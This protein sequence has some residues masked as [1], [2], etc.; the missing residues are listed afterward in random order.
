[1]TYRDLAAR[2]RDGDIE[3][4]R[5]AVRRLIVMGRKP[6]TTEEGDKQKE[7]ERKMDFAWAGV[8]EWSWS[9]E[10]ND[11]GGDIFKGYRD[12]SAAIWRE[13]D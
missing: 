6:T 1:M 7:K 10:K 2:M 8:D 5:R 4:I 13:G 12:V 3:R 11:G 9:V